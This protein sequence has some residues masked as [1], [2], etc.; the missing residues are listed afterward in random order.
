M[1][2]KTGRGKNFRKKPHEKINYQVSVNSAN[3]SSPRGSAGTLQID[4][5]NSPNNQDHIR[6]DTSGKKRGRPKKDST[7]TDASI[8]MVSGYVED[9][10]EKPKQRGSRKKK[11]PRSDRVAV[12]ALSMIVPKKENA[13]FS[14]SEVKPYSLTKATEKKASLQKRYTGKSNKKV[15]VNVKQVS[16]CLISSTIFP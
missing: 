11:S 6:N 8:K 16:F 1:K 2:P 14:N 7:R 10:E 4:W 3:N 12:P 5:V 15:M 9:A 13:R